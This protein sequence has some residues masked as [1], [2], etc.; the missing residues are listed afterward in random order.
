VPRHPR[1]TEPCAA[2]ARSVVAARQPRGTSPLAL[3]AGLPRAA[4]P[5][6]LALLSLTLAVGCQPVLPEA[7]VPGPPVAKPNAAPAAPVRPARATPDVQIRTASAAGDVVQA[8]E[9][10]VAALYAADDATAALYLPGYGDQIRKDEDK[11][12]L[13]SLSGRPMTW[14]EAGYA[15]ADHSLEFTE[16]TARVRARDNGTPGT[17]YYKLGFKR[18]GDALA[19][20]LASRRIDVRPGS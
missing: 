11:Y 20:D 16:V 18:S 6:A 17:I 7:R 15:D 9:A 2:R 10:Y 8:G 3:T 14:G 19:I 1:C 5:L 12:E 4:R 13:D